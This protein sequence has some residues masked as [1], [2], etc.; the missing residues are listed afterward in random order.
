ME[1]LLG[2][3][4]WIFEEMMILQ[5]IDRAFHIEEL[6]RLKDRVYKSGLPVDVREDYVEMINNKIHTLKQK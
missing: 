2:K 5:R 4:Y 1:R 6:H 3:I